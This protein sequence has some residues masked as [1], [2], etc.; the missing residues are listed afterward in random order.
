MEGKR[1]NYFFSC[2]L[3][4]SSDKNPNKLKEIPIRAIEAIKIVNRVH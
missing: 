2:T 4:G 1:H 3:N